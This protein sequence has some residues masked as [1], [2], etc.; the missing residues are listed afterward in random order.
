MVANL[1]TR[2]GQL[3]SSPAGGPYTGANKIINGDMV[4][5]QRGAIITTD[6]TYV[7]DRFLVRLVNQ[8]AQTFQAQQSSLAS[9][10]PSGFINGLKY[11]FGGTAA[12]PAATMVAGIVQK[13]E[14]LNCGDMKFGTA[15][16]K[17]I[18]LSFWCKSSVTGTFGVC[19]FNSAN[20]RSFP[21]T[22]TISVVNTWEYKT[23]AVPGD[24]SGT[25]LVTNG[26]GLQVSWDLGVGSTYSGTATGAWQA[27]DYRGVTSTTKLCATT[28][29]DFFLTGVKLELGSIATPFAPDDYQV[30]LG[31]CYRYYEQINTNASS[32]YGTA[33]VNNT[34]G[35]NNG[36]TAYGYLQWSV[37]KRAIPTITYSSQNVFRIVDQVTAYTTTALSSPSTYITTSVAEVD[38]TVASG[39]TTYRPYVLQAVN[40]TTQYIAVSAEL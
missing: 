26:I 38:I 8:T 32:G 5:D 34:I 29:G 2:L 27:A 31:K 30:S 25:L 22:Y 20:N 11:L 36:T 19:F 28:A 12:A 39:V 14:G 1:T 33:P 15:D 6:N 10:T 17:A 24:N 35:Y 7:V 23:V 4:I 40:N 3:T 18:L 16:A 9:T 13:I 21:A 37:V